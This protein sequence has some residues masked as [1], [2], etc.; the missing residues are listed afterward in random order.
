M[1]RSRGPG[2]RFGFVDDLQRGCDIAVVGGGLVGTSLAYELVARGADV[3]LVDRHH[4]GRATDA[5]AGILS[6]ATYLDPDDDWTVF[7]RA[8]GRHH[9]ELDER[10][11]GDTGTGTGRAECGVLRVSMEEGED[12]W[13][14]TLK[15]LAERRTPGQ[16]SDVEP[17]EAARLFP[18]LGRVRG[19]LYCA[20]GARI[21]GRRATSSITNAAVGRGLRTVEAEVTSIDLENDRAT[22]V[23]TT[24]GR[25]AAGNVAIAGGAWSASFAEALS[26]DLPV[27]PLKGQIVHMTLGDADTSTW[28]VVQPMMS[29]Y[30][31]PWPDSRVACG[32]TLETRAGFDITPTVGGLHELLRECLR[33]APGLS[34]ATV[35]EVRVGLRPASADGRP[36]LG[37]LPG[38]SNI[39]VSTGHG[40]EGLLLGPYSGALV[41]E[42]VVTGSDPPEIGSLSPGRFV[43]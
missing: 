28:P 10:V 9:V 12:E 20:S 36:I 5:G 27:G 43:A 23:T 18:P 4:V 41:A 26:V 38:W 24:A 40:T 37:R 33:T 35:S 39:F 31:V 21:D 15:Q 30:L 42:A 6:A 25:I 29:H 2:V 34:S 16:L 19:A 8:A 1:T 14:S 17:D 3:V 7:A 11:A 13:L 32:G 22:A